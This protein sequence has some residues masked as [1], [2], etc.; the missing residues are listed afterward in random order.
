MKDNEKDLLA[1][2][3]SVTKK[4]KRA[5]KWLE[6]E[7][8]NIVQGKDEEDEVE[9]VEEEIELKDLPII[10]LSTNDKRKLSEI[11][12]QPVDA[13]K[14]SVIYLG[15][16]PYGFFEFQIKDFLSQFGEVQRL[17]ICKNQK[18]GRPK[19]YGFVEFVHPEVA[20][21]VSDFMDDYILFKKKVVC[22]VVPLLQAK[23]LPW[24]AHN[25]V[26]VRPF[27][28]QR[29]Y[30]D[31]YNNSN[32]VESSSSLTKKANKKKRALAKHN[33][34]YTFDGYDTIINKLKSEEKVEA[35]K[36]AEQDEQKAGEQEEK[37]REE[38]KAQAEAERK[39]KADA[40]EKNKKRKGKNDNSTAS[41][42]QRQ[43]A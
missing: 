42:K 7:L 23:N 15:H 11:I 41:K 21:I 33:I 28:A 20:E 27:S 10:P 30:A 39:A 36:Q 32:K 12:N 13:Q 17:Y 2:K 8:D 14:S 38:R 29:E 22:H 18:S 35:A 4:Q 26:D 43:Q 37:M 25:I 40:N 9:G 3:K 16:L 34:D 24:P 31:K 1:N 6:S 5:A 19:G